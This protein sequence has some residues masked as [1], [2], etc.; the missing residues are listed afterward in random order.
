M[1]KMENLGEVVSTDLLIIGG[2]LAGLVAALKAKEYPIDVLLVEKQTIGWS[3]KAPKVGGGL[4][5]MLPEDD[6]DQFAEYHIRNIG[7]YLNDQ[8]LLDA[9]ARESFG[10]VQ[11]MMEWGVGLARDAEGNLQTVRHP[12]GLWSGT[13]IDRDMLFPLRTRAREMGTKIL[14]K[15]HV[16]DLVK[17]GDQVVGAVG[18]NLMD[19]RFYVFQAKATILANGGCNYRVKRLWASGCGDGIAAAYRAGAE[20][21]NPEFGNFFDVDRKDIDFPTPSGAYAF[22][23]NALGENLA[24][25]YVTRQEPD[26]PI[27]VILGMEKEVK[28]GRGPIYL[29]P[30]KTQWDP[31]KPPPF[32]A[33]RWGMPKIL[34]FWN[35]QA[36]KQLKYG[37]LPSPKVEVT[38]ALNAELSPV[39]VDQE[40]KTSLP[41]LW[42]VGDICYQGSAWAGAVPA[43]P[44]RLRGSGVMN[45]LFTSLRG[46][47]SAA[48]FAAEAT[49]P[50]M[51]DAEIERLKKEIFAPTECDRGLSPD[52]AIYSVQNIVCKVEYNLRRS[53]D[54]LEEA[55]SKI[56]KVRQGLSH[57]CAKDGHGLGKCHEAR[58]MALCAE[59]TL[60]AALMRTESRGSHFR[61][62]YPERDD[63]NWLKWIII[64][65]KQG[66]MVLSAEPVPIEKYRIKP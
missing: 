12:A 57:L 34:D 2:G 30:S 7:C 23:S 55:L 20:M 64:K 31:T 10:A 32:F 48:R 40:M 61:E 26:T 59:M 17:Q 62:D 4:W 56:E 9:Y 46:G 24:E 8:E 35:L 53:K 5:V 66:E 13:G 29:D 37:P 21:R 44:G 42:A 36:A 15:V 28:D 45:T 54:R 33:G 3:G 49:F 1:M 39:R 52:D 6:A 19:G 22:L 50:R 16:V 27:S 14:N 11:Q 41:G 18:F 65:K 58:S 43:P 63:R 47:P 38:A 51:D 25:R 60:R